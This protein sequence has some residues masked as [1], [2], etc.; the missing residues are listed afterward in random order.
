MSR[1]LVVGGD[2]IA[3]GTAKLYRARVSIEIAIRQA[4]AFGPVYNLD[5]AA[6]KDPQRSPPTMTEQQEEEDG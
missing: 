2:L 1:K 3:T 5:A 6:L 4:V